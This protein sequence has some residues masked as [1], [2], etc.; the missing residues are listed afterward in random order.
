[1]AQLRNLSDHC[2][3]GVKT[4]IKC[5]KCRSKYYCSK[6]CQRRDWPLHKLQCTNED[7]I[8]VVLDSRQSDHGRLRRYKDR[9]GGPHWVRFLD[10]V[11]GVLRAKLGEFAEPHEYA[12]HWLAI[13][14]REDDDKEETASA[15]ALTFIAQEPKRMFI[16]V[17]KA[18]PVTDGPIIADDE[19]VVVRRVLDPEC[20]IYDLDTDIKRMNMVYPVTLHRPRSIDQV[21]DWDLRSRN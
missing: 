7:L 17:D 18:Q 13:V 4:T 11:Y 12:T 16:F 2:I 21:V 9:M 3:C 8:S 5:G 14:G 20:I 6:S 15:V 19:S 1:M 10:V